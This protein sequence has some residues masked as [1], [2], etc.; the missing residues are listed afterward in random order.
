MVFKFIK[1]FLRNLSSDG[2]LYYFRMFR[3]IIISR[4]I[5]YSQRG[6]DLII[7][8]YFKKS[9]INQVNFIDKGFY[10]DIGAYHPYHNSNTALLH[11]NGWSGCVVDIDKYKLDSFKL[12]RPRR[13]Q[14]IHSGITSGVSGVREMYSF[15]QKG[16]WSDLNTLDYKTAIFYRDIKKIGDFHKHS[17]NTLNINNLLESL[18]HINFLNIDIEGLDTELILGID[19]DRFPIDLIL[20][21]DNFSYSG[22]IDII[23]KFSHHKYKLILAINGSIAYA[24]DIKYL[25]V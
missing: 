2:I 18:P 5:S 19:L 12:M 15:D 7:H 14:I 25:T 21:E 23:E 11:K 6:E 9:F 10:L 3:G 22:N 16:G 8:S 20:F 1:I 13:C 24:R 4:K 17:I